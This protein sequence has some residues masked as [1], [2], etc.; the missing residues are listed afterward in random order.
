M[1]QFAFLQTE[2]FSN[3]VSAYCFAGAVFLVVVWA[4]LVARR[5][6]ARSKPSVAADMMDQVRLYEL[7]VVA[8]DLS[9]R[10]LDLPH[11]F[12]HSL[13]LITVLVVVYRLVGL[14]TT[15]VRYAIHRT[16]LENPA[17][18]QNYATAQTAVMLARGIIWTGAALFT[19]SALGYNVSSV[20]AGLGIGG[21]AVALGAQAV[22]GDFFSAMAI[23]LDK[24]FVVG[25]TIKVGDFTCTVEHIGVKTTRARSLS[26]EMLVFP[27]SMLTSSRIQNFRQLQERRVVVNFTLPLS[28]PTD[29]LRKVPDQIRA[30]VNA[31]PDAR[32]D[33]AHMAQFLD[34][35]FQYEVVFHVLSSDYA[36]YMDAQQAVLLALLDALRADGIPLAQPTRTIVVENKA[37]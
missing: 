7:L 27:N 17:D 25:D 20:L 22:L 8:L 29:V 9:V 16:V 14:V 37:A 18:R 30:I 28:T 36:I 26:G 11:R 13:H 10:Q 15:A 2:Y 34:T 19:F 23:Y 4:F 24:P 1:R 6:I 32:F 33:R 12:E 35:G 3:P 5:L 31:T 21:I